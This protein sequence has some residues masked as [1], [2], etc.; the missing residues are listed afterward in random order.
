MDG[1]ED[2]RFARVADGGRGEHAERADEHRGL[3]REDVAEEVAAHDRVELLRPSHELHRA[4]VDVHVGQLDRRV[5]L[6][7]HL[8][9]QER[10]R[11]G[12]EKLRASP[13]PLAS[14]RRPRFSPVV[15]ERR[16]FVNLSQT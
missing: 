14:E 12:F 6:R 11:E 13:V 10:K 8:R 3:V 1:L 9:A 15:G 16:T 5:L 4:V 7:V 2:A